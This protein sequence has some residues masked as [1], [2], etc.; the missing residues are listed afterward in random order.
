MLY[1]EAGQF[2][3]S[4][5]ADMQVFPIR[6]DRIALWLFLAVAF[7]GVPL[8]YFLKIGPFGHDYIYKAILIPFLILAL[9]AVGL[10]ILT[11]YCGQ[12]SLGAGAFMAIGGYTTAILNRAG[13][14]VVAWDAP[15]YGTSP[16]PDALTVRDMAELLG[17]LIEAT[18]SARTVILGHSNGGMLSTRHVVDHPNTP[19]LVLLSARATGAPTRDH[20]VLAAVMEMIH[21]ATLVHEIGRAHV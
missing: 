6:Q 14:R 15:G 11:G 16:I 2:K 17:R 13:Y 10:N 9:A 20:V 5:A 7:V 3:T 4:Y 1:R 19:A 8:L 21:T 12:I 18:A